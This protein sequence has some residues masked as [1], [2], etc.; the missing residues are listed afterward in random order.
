MAP[1]IFGIILR[2][3]H[4]YKHL[5]N[6]AIENKKAWNICLLFVFGLDKSRLLFLTLKT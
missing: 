2:E 6:F 5:E 4:C 1:L 3:S